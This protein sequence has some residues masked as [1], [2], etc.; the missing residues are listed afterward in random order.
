M[1]THTIY[2]PSA[3]AKF[4]LKNDAFMFF[5]VFASVTS[6]NVLNC[7]CGCQKLTSYNV[8]IILCL[9]LSDKEIGIYFVVPVFCQAVD[10]IYRLCHLFNDSILQLSNAIIKRCM[11]TLCYF[12]TNIIVFLLFLYKIKQY[13]LFTYFSLKYFANHESN[14]QILI[15]NPWSRGEILSPTITLPTN[16]TVV[17][18]NY[19]KYLKNNNILTL[20]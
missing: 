18:N 5:K 2:R 15:L 6:V 13:V 12:S 3:C 10:Y 16:N 14:I 8:V 7:T 20:R 19:A 9:S 17:I 1:K 4:K 11:A